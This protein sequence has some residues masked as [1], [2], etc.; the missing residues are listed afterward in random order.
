MKNID[1]RHVFAGLRPPRF[2]L[3]YGVYGD[4]IFHARRANAVLARVWGGIGNA[5]IP[6][7]PDIG[8][9]ASD[10]LPFLRLLDPDHVGVHTRTFGDL[11]CDPDALSKIRSMFGMQGESAEQTLSRLRLERVPE[12]GNWDKFANQVDLWCSPYRDVFQ[13]QVRFDTRF[14]DWPDR[15]GR[16]RGWLSTVPVAPNFRVVVFDLDE[17]DPF[18]ALM[19]ETRVGAVDEPAWEGDLLRIPV[20]PEDL[21]HLIRLAIS[22]ETFGW[23]LTKAFERAMGVDPGTISSPVRADALLVDSPYNHTKSWTQKATSGYAAP[24]VCVVG[25][26][27]E[28]HALAMLADRIFHHGAWIPRKLLDTEHAPDV[29]IAISRLCSRTT[30]QDHPVFITSVSEDLETVHALATEVNEIFQMRSIP[31]DNLVP[32]GSALQAVAPAALLETH[33]LCRLVDVTAPII[34]RTLPVAV[35][36]G[37]VTTLAPLQLPLPEVAQSVDIDVHWH[38]D[39]WL[40]AYEA[41]ARTA[42]PSKAFLPAPAPAFPDAIIRVN[43]TGGISFASPNK[44][45]ISAGD[46]T[47]FRLA[48]PQLRFPLADDLFRDIAARSGAQIERSPAGVRAQN[49]LEMWGSFAAIAADLTGVT[50][51]I[52]NAFLPKNGTKRGNYGIGYA[53]RNEGFTSLVDISNRLQLTPEDARQRLDHLLLIGVIKRGFLLNCARCRWEAFYR[54]EHVGPTFVCQACGHVSPLVNGRWYAK[55]HEPHVYY[56]L[57][58]VIRDLLNQHGDLPI[59]AASH[60]GKNARSM[61]WSSE[62]SVVLEDDSIELDLCLIVDGRIIVGEAKSNGILK[63]EHGTQEAA[64]R[65]VRAAQVLTADEVVLATSCR[66]WAKDTYELVN[67]AIASHWSSGPQPR[68][69]VLTNVGTD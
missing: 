66:R 6:V 30:N 67:E 29:K 13:D 63:A 15:A 21:P 5:L 3:A 8:Q 35:D 27:P 58:Q 52:L 57:D 39:V 59:L 7:R 42:I 40:P 41:P 14:L 65:L 46:P 31:D 17:V 37:E 36:N 22:G 33:G 24:I 23:D 48:Q 32:I 11:G 10:L 68:L 54:I 28:D 26:E 50:R 12:G 1:F 25:D 20:E 18:V 47:E 61:L 69:V 62:F 38:I 64:Q 4:W 60:L 51:Q 19:I 49:A 56:A 43:R 55:D 9:A 34:R 45:I 44:G 53:I 16:A 2:A